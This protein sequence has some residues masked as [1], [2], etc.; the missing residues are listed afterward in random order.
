MKDKIMIFVIGLLV[1]AVL[2]ASV[3]LIYEK[4][5]YNQMPNEGRMQMMDIPDRGTP[6]D[7]PNGFE[8]DGNKPDIQSNNNSFKNNKLN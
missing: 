5:N 4:T 7:K 2:T 1:G 3:F 8:N 6:P